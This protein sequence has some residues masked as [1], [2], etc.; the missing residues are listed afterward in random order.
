VKTLELLG[1][2]VRRVRKSAGI[3]SAEKLAEIAKL[4]TAT[5][6]NIERMS[7]FSTPE[8]I[9]L[10]AKS[11]NVDPSE[12]FRNVEI[13]RKISARE[14]LQV[15]SEYIDTTEPTC[16]PPPPPTDAELL[17]RS[18]DDKDLIRLT[19][20]MRKWIDHNVDPS[21]LKHFG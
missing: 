3:K 17:L 6:K 1:S 18:L 14:A 4:S 19:E 16:K 21:K 7:N 10:I 15:L 12:L 9:D 5:I 2:N 8:T 20:F 13:E 11:L